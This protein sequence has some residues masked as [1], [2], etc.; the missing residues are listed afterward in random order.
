MRK[1]KYKDNY[2]PENIYQDDLNKYIQKSAYDRYKENNPVS[3]VNIDE[4]Y[5]KQQAMMEELEIERFI[6]LH[7]IN[8]V[9]R[10]RT[11]KAGNQLEVDVY[12]SFQFAIDVPRERKKGVST[13]A[14]KNLN[15]KK[16]QRYV[17]NLISC[18]F[19][20]GDLWCTWTYKETEIPA[21]MKEA[22]KNMQNF[23][24]RINYRRAKRGLPNLKYIYIT[25]YDVEYNEKTGKTSTRI[26][27]HMVCEGTE[28]RDMLE[29]LWKH[30]DRNTTRRI[31]SDLDTHLAGM[32]NYISKDPRGK[33]RW[34]A[35]K[36][37]K[38]PTVTKS[39]S[40]FR[41][42]EVE[43]MTRDYGLIEELM[44]KK[45]PGYK[46]IDAKVYFNKHNQGNYIYARMVRC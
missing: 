5:R 17:N 14:Q 4:Q 24:K 33:K 10:T 21:D 1:I 22:Q 43:R 46:F 41:K 23:I 36:N 45:Y 19:G 11:I 27:H 8:G 44:K 28:D 38:K 3:Q 15:N 12:P 6:V 35:S 7:R 18:N 20:D 26:H 16:A 34:C 13:Q 42:R 9:Y 2:D 40:K 30:G 25:E 37:L 39:Y 31:H 29:K 32:A